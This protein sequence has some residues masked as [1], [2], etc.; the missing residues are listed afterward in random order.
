MLV[1]YQN[2]VVTGAEREV[3]TTWYHSGTQT[4]SLQIHIDD[5][6]GK[7]VF[8][9]HLDY[10]TDKFTAAEIQRLYGHLLNLLWDFNDTA[11]SYPRNKCIHTLFEE[12]AGRTPDKTAVIA[13][14]RTLTYRELNE[15]ANR[16]VLAG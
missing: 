13:C 9:I 16:I 1:S 15:E 14:D 4:E 3:E 2:A 7:G 6:D 12:Q 11:V 5:R 10:R 8:R